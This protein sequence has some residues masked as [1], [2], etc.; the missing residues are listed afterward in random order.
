MPRE[1]RGQCLLG[2]ELGRA[3]AEDGVAPRQI[4]GGGDHVLQVGNAH[5]ALKP[6]L[7][8]LGVAGRPYLR[9]TGGAG[10]RLSEESVGGEAVEA[11]WAR[12]RERIVNDERLKADLQRRR[13]PQ[14]DRR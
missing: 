10:A 14:L 2:V 13:V 7:H 1:V 3:L 9:D 11:T 4:V 8:V 5:G 12:V 6:R